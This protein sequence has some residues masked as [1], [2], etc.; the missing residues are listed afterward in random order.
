MLR[1]I[2]TPP[3]GVRKRLRV[4]LDRLNKQADRVLRELI[5]FDKAASSL[6]QS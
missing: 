4:A 2:I 5:R 3:R 1:P 6:S